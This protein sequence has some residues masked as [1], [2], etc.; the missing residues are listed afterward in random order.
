VAGVETGQQALAVERLGGDRLGVHRG[1]HR[2]D[3]QAEQ[4][5][6]RVQD[7][8]TGGETDGDDRQQYERLG[9][10]QDGPAAVPRHQSPGEDTAD[11]GDDGDGQQ[12]EGQ[13]GV[14]E[15][16]RLL[17]LR[18]P[19]HQSGEGQSLYAERRVRR[20]TATPRPLIDLC[21]HGASSGT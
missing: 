19:R 13:C 3:E 16:V 6:G 12:D 9:D 11:A 1:V 10:P 8:V 17:D 7:Q 5:R 14:T 2:A 21:R 18:D 20:P 15:V 4:R